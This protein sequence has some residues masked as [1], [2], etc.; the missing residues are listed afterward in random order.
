MRC[1]CLWVLAFQLFYAFVMTK[2]GAKLESI[3]LQTASRMFTILAKTAGLY[4]QLRE[5]T[6]INNLGVIIFVSRF[7]PIQNK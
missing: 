1:V 7:L 6:P 2:L 5:K 4:L 3:N